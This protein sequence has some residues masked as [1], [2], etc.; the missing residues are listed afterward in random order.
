MSP[1][2]LLRRL[3]STAT[4]TTTAVEAAANTLLQ[5]PLPSIH[6]WISPQPS[7]L[8]SLSLA[9]YL[10]TSPPRSTPRTSG[11]L[12]AGHHLVYFPPQLPESLLLPDGSDAEQSPGPAWPRRMWVGGSITFC[13]TAP[14]RIFDEA[15]LNE[16]VESVQIKGSKLF[17][18]FERTMCRLPLS[19]TPAIVERRCLVFLQPVT[20]TTASTV[21]KSLK[22]KEK[23]DF[24][25]TFVPSQHLLF[26]FSALTFNAHRI[27]YDTPFSR[28]V[29]GYL[30]GNLCHGPLAVAF[31]LG[32]LEREL[33][34]KGRNIRSF[35]YKCL[36]PMYVGEKYRIAGRWKGEGKKC[37]LWAETPEGGF[38]V[39]GVAEVE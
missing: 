38:S 11:D 16:R 30:R 17:V 13:R 28:D 23:P 24:V 27:H 8:L 37:E 36:A 22:P 14:L 5:R 32:L 1:R 3:Y 25:E 2:L 15:V 21:I 31:L 18:W 33:M 10:N 35:E 29:E 7:H 20:T 39:R 12:P 19:A 26:R 6:D 9:P 34:G 4:T